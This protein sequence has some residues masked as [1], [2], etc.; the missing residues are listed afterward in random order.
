MGGRVSEPTTKASQ[1]VVAILAKSGNIVTLYQL[2]VNNAF[3][4]G[5]LHEEVNMTLPEGY[6]TEND[7]QTEG[8]MFISLFVYVDDIVITGNDI[9]EIKRVKTFLNSK[10]LIKYPGVL[11]YFLGVEVLRNDEN[12]CISQRKYCLELLNDYSML[13][14]K[15]ANTPIDLGLCV[16]CSPSEKDNLLSNITKYQKLFGRL[17]YLTLTRPDISFVVQILSQHMHA[18]LQSHLNLSFRT[19]R[20]LKGS[21]GK[22]VRMVKGNELSLKAYCDADLGKCKLNTR[23]V[24]GYLVYFC[25][26]L[27]SW[28]SKK[29]AT[30][31]SSSAEAEYRAM[32]LTACEIIWIINL[33]R[34]LNINVKLHVELMCDNS[35]AIQIAAYFS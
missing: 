34:D 14:S 30:I 15:P 9:D 16:V 4:Y 13:G 11:K 12:I 19:L 7:K 31:S 32:G 10:F 23:S 29:Q 1:F 25:N 6:F 33:L 21:H 22:G 17:I 20:Y 27:V 5:D 2:D 3:L 8:N 18:P 24:T 26:S 28:K 35:S